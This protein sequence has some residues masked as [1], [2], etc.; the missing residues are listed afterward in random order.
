MGDDYLYDDSER[1]RGS[2]RKDAGAQT[3]DRRVGGGGSRTIVGQ[4][5]TVSAYPTSAMSYYAMLTTTIIGA[6]VEGGPGTIT[7]GGPA[8]VFYALNLGT[9][10]PAS[11]T[12]VAC[13]QVEHRWVL[14]FD[15]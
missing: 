3:R 13:T 14:R 9:A 5:T 11:G 7:P 6:E 8:D 15:G 12:N 10:I 1:L 2:T 4:T